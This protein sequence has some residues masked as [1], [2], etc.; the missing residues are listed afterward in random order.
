MVDTE[1]GGFIKDFADDLE[2]D[3]KTVRPETAAHGHCRQPSKI[4]RDIGSCKRIHHMF[5]QVA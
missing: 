1:N 5:T 3:G 2:S 4:A